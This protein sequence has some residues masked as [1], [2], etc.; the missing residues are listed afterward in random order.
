[1][2]LAIVLLTAWWASADLIIEDDIG[3]MLL[4]LP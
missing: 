4:D 3:C 2:V 1:V